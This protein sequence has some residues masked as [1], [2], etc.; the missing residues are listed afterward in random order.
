M[1]PDS[2]TQ[3]VC[4][5]VSRTLRE[6]CQVREKLLFAPSEACEELKR[7]SESLSEVVEN[8]SAGSEVRD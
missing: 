7:I 2:D 1:S 8:M 5:E 6:L 3:H 4:S